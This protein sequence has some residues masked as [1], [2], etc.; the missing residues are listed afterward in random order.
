L[1]VAIDQNGKSR[2]I[3]H[4]A[5]FLPLWMLIAAGFGFLAGEFCGDHRRHLACVQWANEQLRRS[6]EKKHGRNPAN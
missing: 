3:E 2:I 5:D 4:S 6:A 1:S